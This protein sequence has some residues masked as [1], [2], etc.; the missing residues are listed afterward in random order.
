MRGAQHRSL[1]RFFVNASD[2]CPVWLRPTVRTG[3]Q[4]VSASSCSTRARRARTRMIWS[5]LQASIFSI[6]SARKFVLSRRW[7]YPKLVAVFER[8]DQ[9]FHGPTVGA[10]R[11]VIR[12]LPVI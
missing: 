5:K 9:C 2:T 6:I 8:E 4:V 1:E 11:L 3:A 10:S 7:S 12:S